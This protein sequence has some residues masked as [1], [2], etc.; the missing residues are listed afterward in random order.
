MQPRQQRKEKRPSGPAWGVWLQLLPLAVMF[1]LLWISAWRPF[2][3]S[4]DTVKFWEYLAYGWVYAAVVYW[5]GLMA[6]VKLRVWWLAAVFAWIYFLLYALNAGMIHHTGSLLT[7]YYLRLSHLSQGAAFVRDYFTRWIMVITAACVLNC[8]LAAWLIRRHRAALAGSRVRWVLALA[9]FCGVAPVVRDQGWFRPTYVAVAALH[10]SAQG[11]WRVDQSFSLRLVAE[12]PLVILGRAALGLH[13]QPLQPRPADELAGRSDVLK[14]W[15]LPLGPRQYPPLGLQP[16]DHVVVFAVESLSFDFLAP[17]NTN[18]PPELTP[19]YASPLITNRMFP[20]YQCVAGPTQPGLAATYNS[21]PNTDG[22][23]AEAGFESSVIKLLNAHGYETYMLMSSPDTFLGDNEVFKRMGFQHVLGS[24]TWLQNPD[25]APFINDRGLMDRVL[26]KIA[27]D[28]LDQNRGRKIFIHIQTGD[29]HSPYPRSDYGSLQYPPTPACV[30]R[31]TA[32]PQDR[33]ILASVFRHDFD[34]GNAIAEMRARDLL[35][36]NT[37]VILT[38]DHN[39]PHGEALDRIPGYP[40]RELS[41]IPLV[42][43][44]GQPLPQPGRREQVHSQLDFAPTLAH[45]LGWP[46]PDGW[47]GQSLFAS[48][49]GAPVVEKIGGNLIV[50]PLDGPQRMVSLDHPNGAAEKGLV[51]LFFNVYTNTPPAGVDAGPSANVP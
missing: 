31:L 6:F 12:N 20:D 51:G 35:T 8:L 1:A 10:T 50:M 42:F 7:S 46:V 37:L 23:L 9:V 4:F 11:V 24:Q 34:T 2:D 49:A 13:L 5:L 28:L 3:L 38:A 48:G 32:D 15:Q 44:S 29:T 19:F 43:L 21:H 27:L 39:F 45:L 17:Y 33:A 26:Y 16:F 25:F 41:R 36:T 47:W 40:S 30:A 14:A 18:L 22:I